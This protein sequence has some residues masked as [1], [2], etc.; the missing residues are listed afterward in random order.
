MKEKYFKLRIKIFFKSPYFVSTFVFWLSYDV[1]FVSIKKYLRK[2]L[3]K[4]KMLL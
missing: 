2:V 1:G 4:Y 3:I